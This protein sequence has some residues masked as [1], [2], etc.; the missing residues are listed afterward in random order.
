MTVVW[1]LDV[2]GY[3]ARGGN[4]QVFSTLDNAKAAMPEVNWVET[5][6]GFEEHPRDLVSD[7]WIIYPR[8]VDGRRS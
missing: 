5:T 6:E 8:T 3:H 7:I 2:C 1:V 4:A